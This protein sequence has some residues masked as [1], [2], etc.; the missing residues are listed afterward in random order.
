MFGYELRNGH[1][2][3][4]LGK[5]ESNS[6]SEGFFI[7]PASPATK[8]IWGVVTINGKMKIVEAHY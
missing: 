1:S 3:T 2:I 6:I 7:P 5:I 8:K 4:N